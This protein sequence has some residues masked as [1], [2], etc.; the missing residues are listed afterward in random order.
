MAAGLRVLARPCGTAEREDQCDGPMNDTG[1][2]ESLELE[3]VITVTVIAI[4][5]PRRRCLVL[6]VCAAVASCKLSS[7][8]ANDGERIQIWSE[9]EMGAVTNVEHTEE[10]LEQPESSIVIS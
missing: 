7:Y 1:D 10:Y 6:P 9:S 3:W 5:M 4:A 8:A 2:S